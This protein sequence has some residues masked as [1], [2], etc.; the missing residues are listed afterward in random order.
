MRGHWTVVGGGRGKLRDAQKVV[1]ARAVSLLGD[2]H[3]KSCGLIVGVHLVL[4]AT[5]K[6]TQALK[7]YQGHLHGCG[8]ASA[9]LWDPRVKRIFHTHTHTQTGGCRMLPAPSPICSHQ[10]QPTWSDRLHLSL[11]GTRLFGLGRESSL[12]EIKLWLCLKKNEVLQSFF[13]CT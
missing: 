2:V 8:S 12:R 7:V 5:I 4:K 3:R 11:E 9:K 6:I 10:Y 13:R 1:A